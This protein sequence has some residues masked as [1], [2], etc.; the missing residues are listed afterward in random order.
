M[1]TIQIL[2]A[3]MA[4]LLKWYNKIAKLR[5]RVIKK[6]ITVRKVAIL[7]M[8]VAKHSITRQQIR[9]EDQIAFLET[10]KNA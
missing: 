4:L 8:E 5:L 3:L 7:D 1:K 2:E 6:A 10:K 9:L